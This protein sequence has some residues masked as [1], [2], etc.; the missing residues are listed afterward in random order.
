MVNRDYKV[1]RSRTRE[2]SPSELPW[3]CSAV[4][5]ASPADCVETPVNPQGCESTRRTQPHA[6]SADATSESRRRRGKVRH[7][8]THRGR[9]KRGGGDNAGAVS[10]ASGPR[11]SKRGA[12]PEGRTSDS[13]EGSSGAPS[14]PTLATS[15][16]PRASPCARTLVLVNLLST[17]H[18][19][20]DNGKPARWNGCG[21]RDVLRWCPIR[22]SGGSCSVQPA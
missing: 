12:L 19:S 5:P 2:I 6:Q 15:K 10:P 3:F 14:S 9:G 16:L 8:P 7:N 22:S 4:S 1:V 13:D 20:L 17:N 21:C 11:R 18:A